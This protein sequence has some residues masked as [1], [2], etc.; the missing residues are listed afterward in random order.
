MAADLLVHMIRLCG[1]GLAYGVAIETGWPLW[2][3]L[4]FTIPFVCWVL[5]KLTAT[6]SVVWDLTDLYVHTAMGVSIVAL[7]FHLA[8]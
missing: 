8:I 6:D 5:K 4:A 7:L 2:V 1:G 3:A